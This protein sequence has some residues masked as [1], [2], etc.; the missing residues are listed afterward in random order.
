VELS[1]NGKSKGAKPL[2]ADASPR[3]WQ[4]AFEPGTIQAACKNGPRDELRTAGKAAR[5]V[6]SAGRAKLTPDWNDV[7]YV[8]ATVTDNQ[9]VVVPGANNEVAFQISGPGEVAAV[10]N[11]D[12]ASHESFQGSA[13]RAYQGRC[14]AVIRA[15]ASKGSVTVIGSSVGLTAGSVTIEAVSK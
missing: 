2:P 8:T 9:G 11:A 14:I 7:S 6:L 15:T 3:T 13:R 5:I 1:L 10:D 4:I 12:N